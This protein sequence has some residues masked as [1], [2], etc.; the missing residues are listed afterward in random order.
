MAVQTSTDFHLIVKDSYLAPRDLVVTERRARN[1]VGE[2]YQI[3]FNPD[4]RWFYFPQMQRNEALLFKCYDSAH[5]GR[6]CFA[7]HTA[8]D[9]PTSPPGAAGRESIESRNFVF[10]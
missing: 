3:A 10:F 1:R 8:F 2:I 9:D 7:P 5:D 4:H 6:A